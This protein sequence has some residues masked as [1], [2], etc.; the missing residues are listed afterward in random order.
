LTLILTLTLLID[1][2]I[3]HK[4]TINNAHVDRNVITVSYA[5]SVSAARERDYMGWAKEK[6]PAAHAEAAKFYHLG[7][8]NRKRG[9]LPTSR[10]DSNSSINRER[11]L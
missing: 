4:G 7:L 3:F 9:Q 2:A 1:A 8:G 6:L 11:E 10:N 5:A